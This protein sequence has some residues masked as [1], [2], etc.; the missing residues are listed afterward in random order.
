MEIQTRHN[1]HQKSGFSVQQQKAASP[2]LVV[3]AWGVKGYD[4]PLLLIGQ[5]SFAQKQ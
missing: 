2:N 5:R 1:L 4:G 3:D